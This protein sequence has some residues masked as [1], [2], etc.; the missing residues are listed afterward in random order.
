MVPFFTITPE[1][2]TNK[3]LTEVYLC[4]T[5]KMQAE[6]EKGRKGAAARWGNAR[7][8]AH[9]TPE[10]SNPNPNPNSKEKG[11][12]KAFLNEGNVVRNALEVSD[13]EEL[14]RRTRDV[15]GDDEMRGGSSGFGE[16]A[17]SKNPQRQTSM[18]DNK[19]PSR[20]ASR[21]AQTDREN[22]FSD[23]AQVRRLRQVS[24]HPQAAVSSSARSTTGKRSAIPQP[25][26]RPYQPRSP[27]F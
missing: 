23:P 7:A 12:S 13:E 15:V 8:S 11:K 1:G 4:A 16:R 10:Q 19:P 27:N 24:E 9:A 22:E 21:S 6:S 18:S 26:D 5:S 20:A 14:P 2:W 3:R 17:K 25:R